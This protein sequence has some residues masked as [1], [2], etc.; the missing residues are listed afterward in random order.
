[1]LKTTLKKPG[2]EESF[3]KMIEIYEEP[4]VNTEASP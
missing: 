1:M 2:I 3:P 4:T